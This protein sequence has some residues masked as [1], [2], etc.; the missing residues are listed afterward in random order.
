MWAVRSQFSYDLGDLGFLHLWG[1]TLLTVRPVPI[2][3]QAPAEASMQT[4]DCHD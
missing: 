1:L 2:D 3:V 4:R